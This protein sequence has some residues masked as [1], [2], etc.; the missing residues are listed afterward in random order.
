MRGRDV[1]LACRFGSAQA[2]QQQLMERQSSVLCCK[3]CSLIAAPSAHYIKLNGL[4]DLQHL[5]VFSNI[6]FSENDTIFFQMQ[7]IKTSAFNCF[8]NL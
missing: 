1:S 6:Q 5:R 4:R 3:P 7:N 2:A 8:S